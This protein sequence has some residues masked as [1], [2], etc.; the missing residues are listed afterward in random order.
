MAVQ[1]IS[2]PV[3]GVGAARAGRFHLHRHVLQRYVVAY[4][5]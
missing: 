2:Q 4:L 1:P 3:E 5:F